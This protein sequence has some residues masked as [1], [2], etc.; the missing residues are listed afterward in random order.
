MA[1]GI[2]HRESQLRLVPRP[3]HRIAYRR[4]RAW[5]PNG[6]ATSSAIP[7]KFVAR[8]VNR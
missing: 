5:I 6:R 2:D 1:T 8:V 7:S 3:S 4:I